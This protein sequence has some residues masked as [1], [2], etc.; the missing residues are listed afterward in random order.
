MGRVDPRNAATALPSMRPGDD[1]P[2]RRAPAPPPAP[3]PASELP[4]LSGYQGPPA[5]PARPDWLPPPPG[6]APG[7][8][9]Q[10]QGLPPMELSPK[11]PT[12]APPV[13]QSVYAPPPTVDILPP[14]PAFDE[15][16][17]ES[18]LAEEEQRQRLAKRFYRRPKFWFLFSSLLMLPG[19]FLPWINLNSGPSL[20]AFHL[21]LVMLVVGQKIG[22]AH[23]TA[24][25]LVALLL[26]VN[27]YLSL[28][29][30]RIA[31]YF[32][33][34]A[35][36]AAL[37]TLG[38]LLFGMRSWNLNK[39]D[40]AMYEKYED[41]QMEI[42]IQAYGGDSVIARQDLGYVQPSPTGFMDFM[43][44]MLA[45]GALFPLL[46][47][48]A[49]LITTYAFAS[50]QRF[51]SLQIPTNALAVG[52]VVA[53]FAGVL[54]VLN[55]FFPAHWY[56][57][58]ATTYR[59]LGLRRRQEISLKKCTA[60]PVPPL[61]CEMRLGRFYMDTRR[62]DEAM[63][64]YLDV[65]RRYP[66]E[67]GPHKFIGM[68]NFRERDYVKAEGHFSRFREKI[69]NDKEV[70]EMLCMALR[71]LGDEAHGNKDLNTA[72]SKYEEAYEL[73]SKNKKDIGFN[74]RIAE[75]HTERSA[76]GDL[77]AAAEY[78]KRAAKL[79]PESLKIQT[80]AARALEA[81]REYKDAVTYYRRC[82]DVQKDTLVCY[83]GIAMIEYVVDKNPSAALDTIN[84][85]LAV[86]DVGGPA[87]TL[88]DLRKKIQSEQ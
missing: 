55:L 19:L 20:D 1:K 58:T 77:K 8:S 53:V 64:H 25:A 31:S 37:L 35:L 22:I 43:K 44:L 33:L 24:G 28:R 7:P 83:Y 86:L 59:T 69:K 50:S 72:I 84:E 45:S 71:R 66:G 14:Q 80:D 49:L 18:V 65:S 47:A 68:L 42:L 26:G 27:I 56:Q 62:R 30:D 38:A 60:L 46:S 23:V 29:S 15:E 39:M 70:N 57:V 21:P 81:A 61:S 87:D 32:R 48:F 40:S 34:T 6:S 88:K 3:E 82:I 5:A 13:Q 10:Q 16:F 12:A 2:G 11:P 4:N 75:L 17:V 54:A 79:D 74:I 36:V 51:V 76:K 85:G 52:I 67:P 73:L 78:L 9:A 63:Q 41:R